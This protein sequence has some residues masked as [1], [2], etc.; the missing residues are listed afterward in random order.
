MGQPMQAEIALSVH[1]VDELVA[2]SIF[3]VLD[4]D[5]SYFGLSPVYSVLS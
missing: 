1:E 5:Y 4:V 2:E 3:E